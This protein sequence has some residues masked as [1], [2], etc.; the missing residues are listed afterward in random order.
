MSMRT[1]LLILLA[2]VTAAF[3]AFYARNWLQAERAAIL[4]SASQPQAVAA[5][6]AVSVLVAGKALP[7]GSF[8]KAEHLKWQ[9]WPEDGLIDS[10]AVKGRRDEQAFVGAVVRSAIAAGEPLTDARVVH[11]GDRGFLAAVLEPGK[12]A[13]SV[14]VNAT[15]GIAGFIF[16]GDWVDVI[17]TV[18]FRNDGEEGKGQTRYFSETLLTDVRVLGV[19]QAVENTKGEPVVA[20]TAT[21]EVDP[22]QAEKIAIGLEMGSLSLSLHSLAR[23]QDPFSQIA[24]AI[25]ADPVEPTSARS[26]TMDH[27][28]YYMRDAMPAPRQGKTRAKVNVLRGS[29]AE[30]AAF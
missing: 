3:T 27:D 1:V 15:T 11:P 5:A 20:K 6:P 14:P 8:L 2:V 23:E 18:R 16:P 12:R 29:E 19:D 26:Y 17:L 13:V 7:A 9:A 25:G 28:V 30:A 22:K 24:R 21:L 10:Y 4:A